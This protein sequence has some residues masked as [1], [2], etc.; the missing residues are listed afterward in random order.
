MT[1]FWDFFAPYSFDTRPSI[2]SA[3]VATGALP[4]RVRTL[5]VHCLS[6]MHRP[7]SVVPSGLSR[8]FTSSSS[9]LGLAT[10]SVLHSPHHPTPRI[11]THIQAIAPH[12]C[13]ASHYCRLLHLYLPQHIRHFSASQHKHPLFLASLLHILGRIKSQLRTC[14]YRVCTSLILSPTCSS[15]VLVHFFTSGTHSG[16]IATS[17]ATVYHCLAGSISCFLFCP[18][19]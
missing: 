14:H 2:I 19:Q 5:T 4:S 11:R 13:A 6:V 15:P 10:P 7:Y 3:I 1:P 16:L 12:I 18:Q 17:Y 9:L 8:I